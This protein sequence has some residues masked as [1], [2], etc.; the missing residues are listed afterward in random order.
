MK[1]SELSTDAAMDVLCEITPYVSN[2][3][4]DDALMEEL[5][6]AVD[7]PQGSTPAAMLA[8]GADKLTKLVPILLKKRRA[9]MIGI[10]AAING[11][12]PGE[13]GKQNVL[14]TIGQVWELCRD[15]ELIDFFKSCGAQKGTGSSLPC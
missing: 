13:I 3:A 8:A 4:T 1:L 15:R 11:K 2:I 6:R 9:D 10:L 7:L 12:T 14:T 5:K